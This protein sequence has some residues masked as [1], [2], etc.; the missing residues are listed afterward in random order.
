MSG[1]VY[2]RRGAHMRRKD[3]VWRVTKFDNG[4]ILIKNVDTG[5]RE[6][7]TLEAWR[8]GFYEGEIEMVGARRAGL[9]DCQQLRSGAYMRRKDALWRVRLVKD[10]VI[11][12]ENVRTDET[13]KLRITEWQEGCYRGAI[14]MVADP[15]I[16]LPE[17]IRELLLVPLMNQPQS[18]QAVVL[19]AAVFVQ[20]YRDP[21]AFYE[22]KLPQVKNEARNL[23]DRLSKRWIV[24][25]LADVAKAYGTVRPGFSTFCKW[26]QKLDLANGDIRAFAPRYDRRGPHHRGPE[27]RAVAERLHRRRVAELEWQRQ[28][29]GSRS[30]RG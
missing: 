4:R 30:S 15:N 1:E 8:T 16:D 10:R 5:E 21:V 13:D 14:E 9:V 11:H 20:A 3:T 22:R 23:P 26:L 25:F 19:N 2:L 28:E 27:G 29:E 6:E 24:P 18:M 7:L 17:S 12:L